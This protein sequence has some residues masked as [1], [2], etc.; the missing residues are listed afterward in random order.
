MTDYVA[1]VCNPRPDS[2]T[3]RFWAAAQEEL[4]AAGLHGRVVDLYRDAWRTVLST[5][6]MARYGDHAPYPD[7]A[8]LMGDLRQARLLVFA[9]PVWMYGLAAPLKGLLERVIRPGLTFAIADGAARPLL[10]NVKAVLAVCSSGQTN[11]FAGPTEDPVH[12]LF[13]ELAGDNF[14]PGCAVHYLRL[15]GT[16]CL[17]G[18][19]AVDAFCAQ[20]K[21]GAQTAAQA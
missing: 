6:D 20:V 17:S 4:T 1:F 11:R 12:Y 16:D 8:D 13:R 10:I 7:L 5:D 9:F 14:A 21:A 2:L 3:Y 15:F 19:D 18:A